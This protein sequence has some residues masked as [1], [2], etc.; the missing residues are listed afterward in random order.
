VIK[1]FWTTGPWTAA[2]TSISVH[3]SRR[4]TLALSQCTTQT[5][6]GRIQDFLQGGPTPGTVGR[7]MCWTN[8]RRYGVWS[9]TRKLL[10]LD[11]HAIIW[12]KVIL[13]WYVGHVGGSLTAYWI[14]LRSERN[15]SPYRIFWAIFF[16][17][18][19]TSLM[20][21][22]IR[23]SRAG[24]HDPPWIH[25]CVVRLTNVWRRGC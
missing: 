20:G 2:V 22:K 5:L 9:S 12:R 1:L 14:I 6:H 18:E 21:K 3:N 16:A 4:R 17:I 10:N 19:F 7:T 24:G 15:K 11:A 23:W 8:A 25:A 13:S